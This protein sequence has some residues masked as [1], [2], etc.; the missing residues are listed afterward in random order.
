M[1]CDTDFNIQHGGALCALSSAERAELRTAK[2]FAAEVFDALAQR[3]LYDVADYPYYDF[4]DDPTTDWA[5]IRE[6]EDRGDTEA[7]LH[8]LLTVQET[9]GAA[10]LVHILRCEVEDGP[11]DS[12]TSALLG[13][14]ADIEDCNAN[15][16][17]ESLRATLD[18]STAIEGW[19][20]QIYA[21]LPER[22]RGAFIA[23]L[24]EQ[25]SEP[26]SDKIEDG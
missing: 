10:H 26:V 4:G 24:R 7:A 8:E 2:R 22:K 21:A 1:S 11:G 17:V 5:L 3:G 20:T 18:T 15:F 6:L 19:A 25:C 23:A 12:T 9:Q 13:Y 16:L 14:L